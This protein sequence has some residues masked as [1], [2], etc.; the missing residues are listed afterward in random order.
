MKKIESL[1]QWNALSAKLTENG[2]H[3]GQWQYDT[4]HSEGFHARFTASEKPD[5][6]FV[7]YNEDVYK[8]IIKF[9]PK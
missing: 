3:I 8:A 2:Y 9:R 7:T 4:A 5:I 6:E 1:E